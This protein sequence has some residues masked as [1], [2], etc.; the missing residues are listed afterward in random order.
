MVPKLELCRWQCW[1]QCQKPG[2]SYTVDQRLE[3]R[4]VIDA[5]AIAPAFTQSSEW[6]PSLL[7]LISPCFLLRGSQFYVEITNCLLSAPR[8]LDCPV[9]AAVCV[10]V[11]G[12]G[13]RQRSL[14]LQLLAS[15]EA[16]SPAPSRKA[17]K[18]TYLCFNLALSL[19]CSA[20]LFI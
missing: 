5:N 19:L 2:H 6:L 13:P 10:E 17:L 14:A 3:D 15:R 16:P 12:L 4:Q 9:W 11:Q 8:P 18:Q 7:G 1:L 20:V